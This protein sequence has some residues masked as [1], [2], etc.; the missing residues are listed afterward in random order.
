MPDLFDLFCQ[1]LLFLVKLLLKIVFFFLDQLDLLIHLLV[2]FIV[3]NVQ[4]IVELL[5]LP[6][7]LLFYLSDPPLIL[8]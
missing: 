6:L 2:V 8:V 3:L 4:A 5:D 7:L 1:L